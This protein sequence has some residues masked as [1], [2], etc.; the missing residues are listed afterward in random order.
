MAREMKDSGIEWIGEIPIDWQTI[1]FKYLHNGLNT[2]EAIGKEDWSNDEKQIVFYS[3][4]LIPQRTNYSEFPAWKYTT[5]N[6]LLL[7]R[8]GTPY[9]YFPIEGACYSDHIIR[10]AMKK[11]INRQFVQYGLQQSIASVVVD[12]VSIATWSASLWN[13]QVIAWP[14]YEEQKRIVNFLETECSR[15]DAVIVQTR[16][17]IEEYKKL[18]QAVI[19]QAVTKGIR[20]G[21]QMKDSGVEWI[22]QMPAEWAI[23]KLGFECESMIVP[24]RDKPVFVEYNTGIPWCRIEDLEGRYLLRSKCSRYVTKETINEMNL[25]VVPPNTVL[26]A[27][28]AASV[29]AVAIVKTP[30]CTN[31]TFIGLVAGTGLSYEYLYYYIFMIK[32]VLISLGMGATIVYLS[33][34]IYKKLPLPLLSMS[35]QEEIVNYLNERINAIDET[36]EKKEKM[37]MDLESYKKSLIYEYVTGKK[38]VTA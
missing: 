31:Q 15:I 11:G 27:C 2:G 37:I 22:G 3:A 6:D 29:G 14:S 7:A 24:M 23:S 19:T 35:E 1:K 8:N 16:A 12:S 21:R 9:V 30:C 33:K 32:P 20:P 36:I 18:K 13:E 34:D 25:K 4:G 28:S 10:S 5:N 17:S 26:S 38:E